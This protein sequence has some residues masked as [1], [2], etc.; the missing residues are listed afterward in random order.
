MSAVCLAQ[1]LTETIVTQ[2][3]WICL[4]VH[5]PALSS[6]HNL[7]SCFGL[8][9]WHIASGVSM[10]SARSGQPETCVLLPS[11]DRAI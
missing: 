7:W 5:R 11:C 4:A 10:H 6:E 1:R 2:M 3:G 8:I 9:I